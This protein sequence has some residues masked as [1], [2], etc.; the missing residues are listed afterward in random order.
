MDFLAV[1]FWKQRQDHVELHQTQ[2]A[3]LQQTK[4][5]YKKKLPLNYMPALSH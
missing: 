2:T 4:Q 5:N 1:S 3:R